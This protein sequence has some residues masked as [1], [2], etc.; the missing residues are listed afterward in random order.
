MSRNKSGSWSRS[1]SSSSSSMSRSR[2]RSRRSANALGVLGLTLPMKICSDGR[3][4]FIND[5]RKEP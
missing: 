2:S 1:R 3:L 4:T 5:V